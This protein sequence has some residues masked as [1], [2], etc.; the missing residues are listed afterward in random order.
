[1]SVVIKKINRSILLSLV[2][3]VVESIIVSYYIRWKSMYKIYFHDGALP[4]RAENCIEN[5]G[6]WQR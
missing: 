4:G 2:L 1:M 6:Y 3:A 5:E